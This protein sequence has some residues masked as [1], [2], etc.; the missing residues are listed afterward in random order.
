MISVCVFTNKFDFRFQLVII[1][2]STHAQSVVFPVSVDAAGI[3]F[4]LL[5]GDNRR[6]FLYFGILGNPIWT[7][8]LYFFHS[9]LLWLHFLKFLLLQFDSFLHLSEEDSVFIICKIEFKLLRVLLTKQWGGFD[10]LESVEVNHRAKSGKY[11]RNVVFHFLI[12][13]YLDEFINLVILSKFS[14]WDLILLH[15]RID[16][17]GAK[18]LIHLSSCIANS[19]VLLKVFLIFSKLFFSLRNNWLFHIVVER[20]RQSRAI[21]GQILK[22]FSLNMVAEVALVE[23]VGLGRVLRLL[24]QLNCPMI[25]RQRAF[26]WVVLGKVFIEVGWVHLIFYFFD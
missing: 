21:W 14:G 11:L 18:S 10:T 15:V 6:R 7:W 2:S 22:S 16:H 4:I 20:F 26:H 19:W 3:L 5:F 25:W 9:F 24:R 12:T 13:F 1:A 8:T 17:I 23:G